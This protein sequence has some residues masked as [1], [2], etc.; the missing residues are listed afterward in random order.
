[1]NRESGVEICFVLLLMITPLVCNTCLPFGT[2]CAVYSSFLTITEATLEDEGIY[3]CFI[4]DGVGTM[5][6]TLLWDAV[7]LDMDIIAV[8]VDFRGRQGLMASG[9]A[10]CV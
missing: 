5:K 10:F 3:T 9:A 1:M 2:P 7:R 4:V 8:F 6:G